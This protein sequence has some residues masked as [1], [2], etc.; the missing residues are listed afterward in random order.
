V[1]SLGALRLISAHS[2]HLGDA[3]LTNGVPLAFCRE[4]RLLIAA[5]LGGR[6]AAAESGRVATLTSP[7]GAESDSAWAK[8]HA[9]ALTSPSAT[10]ITGSA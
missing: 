5:H 6:A 1:R 4:A 8:H 2:A 9:A 10:A 3:P 7:K